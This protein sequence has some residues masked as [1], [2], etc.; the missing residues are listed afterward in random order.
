[1]GSGKGLRAEMEGFK[2]FSGDEYHW[3][4]DAA[5][6]KIMQSLDVWQRPLL[7]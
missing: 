1:M 7:R 5:Q 4:R 3:N 6:R 2:D